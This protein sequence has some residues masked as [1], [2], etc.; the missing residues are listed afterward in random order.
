MN[1]ILFNFSQM[2]NVN[3]SKNYK[4]VKINNTNE[5]D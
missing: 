5:K 1:E 3:S 2:F 4:Y